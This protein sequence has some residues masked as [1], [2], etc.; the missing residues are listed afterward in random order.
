MPY[1]AKAIAKANETLSP[2]GDFDLDL[3]QRLEGVSTVA[4]AADELGLADAIAEEQRQPLAAFLAQ[5]PP[6]ID[7]A[8]VAAARNAL[9]RGVRVTLTWQP[10]YAHELPVWDVA[11]G[12]EGAVNIHLTSPHPIEA[13]PAAH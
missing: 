1:M 7:A 11:A 5:L 12:E 13:E 3:L 6:A 8:I 4:E 2:S 10:G 9:T